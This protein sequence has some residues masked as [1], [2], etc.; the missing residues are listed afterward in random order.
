MI[1]CTE[2]R[3]HIHL[4]CL[5]RSDMTLLEVQVAKG[6]VESMSKEVL[7]LVGPNQT[8]VDRFTL[9]SAFPIPLQVGV[10]LFHRLFSTHPDCTC[11]GQASMARLPGLR[12]LLV[13]LQ[14]G[15]PRMAEGTRSLF[16]RR[17]SR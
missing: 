2:H 3:E 16:R 10:S 8:I 6:P 13:A 4:S 7:T 14:S 1:F 15:C 11:H 12:P 17:V 5:A 9:D